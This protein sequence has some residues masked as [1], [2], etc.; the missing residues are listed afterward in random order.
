MDAKLGSGERVTVP[1]PEIG[2]CLWP[3]DP[4]FSPSLLGMIFMVHKVATSKS[5]DTAASFPEDSHSVKGQKE[6]S[7]TH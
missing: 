3:G 1:P 7:K 6:H 5:R 2:L 4:V